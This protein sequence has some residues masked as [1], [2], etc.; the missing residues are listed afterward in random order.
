MGLLDGK[1]RLA[2]DHDQ[3]LPRPAVL[4]TVNLGRYAQTLWL[5]VRGRRSR[6]E[7]LH[8]AADAINASDERRAVS[9]PFDTSAKQ[10]CRAPQIQ[11]RIHFILIC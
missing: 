10:A 4:R 9:Q 2:D 1:G 11:A 8:H 3:A 6:A 7:E 5:N